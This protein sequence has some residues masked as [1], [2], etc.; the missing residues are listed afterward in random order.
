MLYQMKEYILY[1]WR[2]EHSCEDFEFLPL[3]VVRGPEYSIFH[4]F[5]LEGNCVQL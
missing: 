5:K 2:I 3:K 1:D 4:Y